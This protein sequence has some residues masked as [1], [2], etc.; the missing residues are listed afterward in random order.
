MN[1]SK[2]ERMLNKV[3][4]VTLFFWIIKVLCTTVGETAAD[5]LSG[6]LNFG[7]TGTS[8][9]MSSILA[10]II[11][12]QFKAKEY[13]PFIYWLTVVFISIVG[14]L[15]TDNLTDKM[16]VPLETTTVVFTAMLGLTFIIWYIFEKTL[17]IYSIDTSRREVFYWMVVL[18]TFA[19]GTA[20]GDLVAEKFEIGYL[21]SI[22]IFG[23]I[24]VTAIGYYKIKGT[25]E[26]KH[27]STFAI[28]VFWIAYIFTRPLGA[29]IGDFLSQAPVDGGLGL[30]ATSTSALFMIT[31]LGLVV[32]LTLTRKTGS[33][34][35]NPMFVVGVVVLTCGLGWFLLGH[36]SHGKKTSVVEQNTISPLGDLTP[37]VKIAE[38]SLRL[39]QANDLLSAK[40]RIKDLETAWD[41]AEEKLRSMSLDDWTSVD[42][43]IDRVLS[44]L[45]A[46]KPD[47]NACINALNALISKSRELTKK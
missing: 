46:S 23:G 3:P 12:F 17:S 8:L 30:G 5:Y 9:I 40:R 44:K 14:T 39:V 6:T 13:V 16:A 22:F 27:E 32:Y 25:A 1:S 34:R 21:K 42:T 41:E 45:R 15:I 37:F 38:D 29:S 35:L 4:E 18:F 33:N 7:L 36:S 10:V 24:A 26:H 19:L 11:F 31:I 47:R 2:M 28:F 20:A 43:S